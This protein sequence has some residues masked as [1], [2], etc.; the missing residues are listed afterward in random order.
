LNTIINNGA[1][2]LD[3]ALYLAVGGN[4][5]D[6]AELLIQHGADVNYIHFETEEPVILLAATQL[7]YIKILQLL[8]KH[9]ADVNCSYLFDVPLLAS[10]VTNHIYGSFEAAK[11]LLTH[12]KTNLNNDIALSIRTLTNNNHNQEY[13]E[14]I[15][16]IV[17]CELLYNQ[18]DIK[19]LYDF[20]KKL[21]LE[22]KNIFVGRQINKFNSSIKYF[23]TMK[24]LNQELKKLYEFLNYQGLVIPAVQDLNNKVSE[25]YA[26]GAIKLQALAASTIINNDISYHP[27]TNQLPKILIP[28]IDF[29]A[30]IR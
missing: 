5:F 12:H 14:N 23:K 7:N 21:S 8:V 30:T 24:S 25:Y 2:D 13:I 17:K 20:F 1:T 19:A 10:S 11:Y 9:G 15:K 3:R 16:N 6:V 26:C 29:F 4:D 18:S 22:E 28:Y 27:S